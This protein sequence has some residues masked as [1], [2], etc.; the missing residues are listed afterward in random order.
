MCISVIN[1]ETP[2][3]DQFKE[4][5]FQGELYLFQHKNKNVMYF[6]Y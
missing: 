4:K 6:V 5:L 2:K 3:T 1:W